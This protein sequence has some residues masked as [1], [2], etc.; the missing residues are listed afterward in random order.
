MSSERHPRG[1]RARDGVAPGAELLQNADEVLAALVRRRDEANLQAPYDIDGIELTSDRLTVRG[2]ADRSV[3]EG[4]IVPGP[5]QM[6]MADC[7]GWIL[8]VARMPAGSDALT[9]DITMHFFRPLAVGPYLADCDLLGWSRRRSIVTMRIS[10]GAGRQIC[11]SATLTF[12][13]RPT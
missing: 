3:R 13:P 4:G 12:A 1:G 6:A 2:M 11:S 7:F 8:T 9:L 10:S 5:V